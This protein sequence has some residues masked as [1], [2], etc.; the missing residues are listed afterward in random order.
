MKQ[1]EV[2]KLVLEYCLQ[3]AIFYKG[4]AS[5]GAVL[6]KILACQCQLRKDIDTVKKMVSETVKE[7]NKMPPEKQRK[8][9]EDL[10]PEMLKKE[11]KEQ[12]LLPPL[13][14]AQ[15]G[16]VVTRF[17]PAPTGPLHV[18]HVL[19]AVFINL[20]YAKK[21]KGKFLLRFEDTDPSKLKSEYYDWIKEDLKN[22]GVKWDKLI[23]QSENMQEYYKYA[24]QLIK[25]GKMYVCTCSQEQF[26]KLKEKKKQCECRES[27]SLE[28]WEKMLTGKIKEG[29]CVV[30]L[31][32]SMYDPNPA[33]RDPAMFRI[34]FDEHPLQKKKYC[35]WPLYNFACA[36]ED[37]KG[38]ITHVFRGKEHEH[39]T[40]IQRRLYNALGW[41][42]PTFI[43]FGMIYFPGEKL[44]KRDIKAMIQRGEVTGWDDPRLHTIRAL[45]RRGFQPEAFRQCAL[46]CGLSKTDI[47]FEFEKLES[48]NRRII[49]P[50]ANRYMV[51]EKPVTLDI[52]ELLEKAGI[53]KGLKKVQKHPEKSDTKELS[54]SEKVYVAESDFNHFKG[55]EVRLIELFNIILEKIPKL[56]KN[57]NDFDMKT[58]KLQWVSEPNINVKIIIPGKSVDAI[59]ENAMNYLKNGDIIQM[60]RIG[61]A[62]VDDV[63]PKGITVIFSHK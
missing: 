61:F 55:K 54:I 63:S 18:G 21:Y 25:E 47:K 33:L 4:K 48:T 49:D 35:V 11:V 24:T 7:V 57:Y 22:L 40:E 17:A 32:T 38:G 50:I 52:S 31:K 5:E 37:Y 20:E 36:V 15:E 43:N 12:E 8:M 42:H 9:L 6:G 1:D 27:E 2:K 28:T 62:R 45:L 30:R 44:H 41:K 51:V 23:I 58:Q 10:A 59:G 3:N 56:S 34:M 26:K 29:Q 16:K 19:R 60:L 39:N 46:G 53:K 14:G 13:P